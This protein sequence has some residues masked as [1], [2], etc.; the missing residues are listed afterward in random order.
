MAGQ[1]LLRLAGIRLV[2][3]FRVE[4]LRYERTPHP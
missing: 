3:L 2:S 4:F 1:L